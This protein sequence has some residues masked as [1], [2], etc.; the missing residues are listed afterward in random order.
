MNIAKLIDKGE[1]A[2]KKKNFDYA[3]EILLQAVSFAPNNRRA[4]E[5]LRR[6]ELKK[7]EHSYPSAAVVAVFALPARLGIWLARLSKKGNPESFM[8]ACEKFLT[9]DPKNKTVNMALGQAAADA[10]HLET[11]IF[12]YETASEHNPGDP[13]AMKRLGHLLWRNGQIREAHEVFDKVVALRPRDQEAIKARKNLAAEVSLK[14]TGF[15]SA[16]SSRE[17]VKDKDAAGKLE[18]ETRIYRTEEDL[19]ARRAAIEKQ[20]AKD[21]NNVE[22]LKDLVEAAQRMKDWDAALETMDR[23]VELR[24]DDNVLVFARGDLQIDRLEDRRLDLLREGKQGEA[25]LVAAELLEVRIEEFRRRVRAY[26]TDVNLRFK[27]G[28][29]LFSKGQLEEAIGAFQQ[30]V[31]DPKFRA[32]SQLRLGRAFKAKGQYDLSLRQLEQALEGQTGLSERVK[33][34]RYE[35]GDVYALQGNKAEAK[36]E[37]GRIYE[38]DIGYRDVADRLAAL[39]KLE[40]A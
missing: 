3:M 27:L 26:P 12:A 23:A 37:F 33:E 19:Q 9:K 14:E 40:S 20:L 35:M 21:P 39:D 25:D 4:R 18:Q 17:L 15:E 28:E 29:L 16:K 22:L 7:Y 2:L 38:Q 6:A 31:R 13:G 34:I 10:G 36:A 30:T 1:E 8:M 24:P 5:M 11:A 32:E